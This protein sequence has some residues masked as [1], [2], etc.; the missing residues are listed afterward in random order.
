M[1]GSVGPSVGYDTVNVCYCVENTVFKKH[2]FF[3]LN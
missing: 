3:I 2:Y 1:E